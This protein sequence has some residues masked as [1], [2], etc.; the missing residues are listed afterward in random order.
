ML[1]L[2]AE[3]RAWLETIARD[4]DVGA[5]L[6][7]MSDAPDPYRVRTQIG[8]WMGTPDDVEELRHEIED[9]EAQANEAEGRAEDLETERDDALA[10]VDSLRDRL[11]ERDEELAKLRD[12]LVARDVEL[13]KLRSRRGPKKKVLPAAPLY[14]HAALTGRVGPK[15]HPAPER[16]REAHGHTKQRPAAV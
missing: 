11:S 9:L 5:L 1:T 15:A 10:E 3:Q 12:Q 13:A 6:D 8:D 7:E 4:G 2:S 14:P 16:K